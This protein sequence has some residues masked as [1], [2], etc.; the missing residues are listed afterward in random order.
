MRWF[1]VWLNNWFNRR[2]DTTSH[3]DKVQ[4]LTWTKASK[5][6]DEM[7]KEE[8]LN[9]IHKIAGRIFDNPPKP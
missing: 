9:F 6:I 4:R 2:V 5:P 1:W 8:R 7:S 3:Q